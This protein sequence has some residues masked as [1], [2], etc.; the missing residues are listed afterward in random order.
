MQKFLLFLLLFLSACQAYES[1]S[2]TTELNGIAMT[3]A[4]RVVIA[5][6]LSSQEHALVRKIIQNVFSEIDLIFNN[7]NPLSEISKLNQ[8]KA[9][10]KEPLSSEMYKFL[11]QA[12]SLVELTNGLFDPTIQPIY[13]LWKSKLQKG[14]IPDSKEISLILP[15]IGW[16]KVHYDNAIFFKDHDKTSIDLGGIAKGHCVDLLTEKLNK[17]GFLNIYVEWG[18]EVRASGCHPDNRPWKVFISRLGDV[19]PN[20]GIA[21]VDIINTALATS[22][23]YLQYW[24]VKIDGKRVSYSHIID[25]R[26]YQPLR[27][28]RRSIASASIM[29]SNCAMADGIA[30][31]AMLL[32]NVEEAENWY[33]ELKKKAPLHGCWFLSR[34]TNKKEFVN[35]KS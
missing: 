3:I 2:K 22:G 32:E 34:Y 7:W 25:P 5:K 1:P 9:D 11:L 31:A 29:A 20:N 4:Y 14:N 19:D 27:L 33:N 8:L 17:A 10:V 35:E 16:D 28:T 18:G 23:D 26:S 13:Q 15:A 21:K 30:T 12:G 6:D 24:S